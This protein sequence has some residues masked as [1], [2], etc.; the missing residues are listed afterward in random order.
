VA[1]REG[2]V[3]VE[4]PIPLRHKGHLLKNNNLYLYLYLK[5]KCENELPMECW[6]SS[7]MF[8]APSALAGSSPTSEFW[9]ALKASANLT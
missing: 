2:L 3:D 6:N 4:L 8:I 7:N 9:T 1:E 5:T